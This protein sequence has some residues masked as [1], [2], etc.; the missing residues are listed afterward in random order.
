M[1]CFA[2]FVSQSYDLTLSIGKHY[3]LRFWNRNYSSPNYN[4]RNMEPYVVVTAAVIIIV[5]NT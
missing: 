5:L 2:L 4:K 1:K 3:T